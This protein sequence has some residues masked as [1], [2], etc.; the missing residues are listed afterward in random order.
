MEKERA[1]RREQQEAERQIQL[2]LND[3][4]ERTVSL[5]NVI[6]NMKSQ[7]RVFAWVTVL[8]ILIG[9]CA[10]LILYP[11]TKAELTV[12]SVVNLRYEAPV[13][14]TVTDRNGKESRVVPD[15]PEYE[16]VSDLSAPD[17]GEL[18]L[19]QI[20]SSY[21]LQ[22]ALDGMTLS[23]PITAN[24]LR[25]NIRIQTVM[26]EESRRT[27]EALAGLA[28]IKNAGAYTAL[29][30]AEIL[31]EP[32]FVVSLSN[33]F[34]EEGSENPLNKKELKPEELRQVL[35]RVLTV[36]NDYLVRTYADLRLPEDQFSVIDIQEMDIQ[37]SLDRLRAGLD[38]LVDYGSGK[39]DTIR[40]YRSWRTGRSLT[41]WTETLATFREINADDLYSR[42]TADNITGN[43]GTLL[44]SFRYLL[45]DA[46]ASLQMLQGQMEETAKTLKNYKN[47]NV[48]ITMQESD[49][50]RNTSMTTDYYNRKITE[51]AENY[52]AAAEL[53]YTIADYER[54]VSLLERDEGTPVTA[55]TLAEL[56]KTL[57]AAKSL[58]AGLREHMEEVFDSPLYTN[59]AEHSVPQGK[60]TNFL[61]ASLKKMLL[62]GAAGAVIALGIWFLKGLAKEMQDSREGF[63]AEETE[64]EG[65]GA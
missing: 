53:Q 35:D 40:A 60:E 41:D 11:L 29:Q 39:S 15:N 57:E 33:G 20:T 26:T 12:S 23:Q 4:E 17:G 44:T 22:T 49:G 52:R 1:D 7:R 63:A 10:P 55:E 24:N 58:Y 25:T 13:K 54:R 34:T 9:I 18:D 8:C 30:E 37:D 2:V 43:R 16:Q 65:A 6:Y 64:K 31:Y 5:R 36:Y 14:V 56:E 51:Q 19:N 48:Y 47:D 21:V 45:R 61:V 38:A 3:G 32:R 50:F 46:K 28:E 42:V 59:Y 62:G 27:Q